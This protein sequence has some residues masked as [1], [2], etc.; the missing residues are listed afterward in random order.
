MSD[1][2]R[3]LEQELGTPLFTRTTRR[4]TLTEAGTELLG[5]AEII[6][7]LVAQATEVVSAIGRGQTGVVRMGTTPPAAS[8][9][10][11]H[12]ADSF[13]MSVPGATVKIQRMWLPSAG[14]ALQAGTIDVVLTCGD[15]GIP[16]AAITTVEIGA[17]PL[18]VGLRPGH[19]L[20]NEAT[21]DLQRLGDRTLGLYPA[22][23]FPAWVAVQRRILADADLAPPIV[24]LGDTDLSARLWAQ[25]QEVEWVMLVGS[26]LTGHEDTVTLP[27]EGRVVPFTLSWPADQVLRP[28][29]QRFIDVSRQ[30]DLPKGWL[31]PT[32]A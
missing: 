22:P 28:V 12:L 6:L 15:L 29:V 32:A 2:I 17:E 10:A 30:T 11:P 31:R 27:A 4:I 9:L 5:R 13:A 23:L 26:L 20:A 21:V 14:S 25:Q 18:L 19:D 1:L 7:D 3:R 8:V 16:G 24:E